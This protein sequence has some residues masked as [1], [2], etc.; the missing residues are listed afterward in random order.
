MLEFIAYS[1]MLIDHIGYYFLNNAMVFRIIGRISMPCF[2]FI[3]VRGFRHTENVKNYIIRVFLCACISQPLYRIVFEKD[4]LNICFTFSLCLIIMYL[5]NN[6]K[7]HFSWRVLGLTFSI[8]CISLASFEYEMYAV[9]L[10][11]GYTVIGNRYSRMI[12]SIVIIF[13]L[14]ITF[15][16]DMLQLYSVFGVVICTILPESEKDVRIRWK[17]MNYFIYPLH[18]LLAIVV[19]EWLH[20]ILN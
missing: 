4:D 1:S 6:D 9:A 11:I 19:K 17:R 10:S 5:L 3:L 15:E 13:L 20:S 2:I 12:F 18:L 14:T 8:S 7:M 16:P